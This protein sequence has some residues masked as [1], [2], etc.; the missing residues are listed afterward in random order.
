M[1]TLSNVDYLTHSGDDL[2][3]SNSARVSFGKW[4]AELD[5]ADEKLIRYLARNGHFSPFTHPQITLRVTAPIM[6]AR[7]LFRHVVGLTINEVSRRYI[8][9]PPE[10]YDPDP[11]P[12]RARADRVK[13]GSGGRLPIEG[14]IAAD[15]VYR[16]ALDAA[17]NAYRTL[18]DVGVCPEMARLVLPVATMTQW[19]WTGSLAAYARVCRLRSDGHAQ[20]ETQEVAA[21]ISAVCAGLFPVSWAA[22]MEGA[23]A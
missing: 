22:L 2:L 19:V 1:A 10:F 21:R 23:P 9:T 16:E 3:V 13:Q 8:D 6:V 11:M 17:A 15:A 5:E 20:A 14:M 7:Q 4:K 18:L 12:W